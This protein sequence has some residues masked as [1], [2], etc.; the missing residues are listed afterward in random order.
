[1]KTLVGLLIALVVFCVPA[2][3]H[4]VSDGSTLTPEQRATLQQ[5]IIKASQNPVGNIAIVPFQNNFNYGVGP[6]ARSQNN[7]N[8]QPVVPIMLSDKWNLIARTILPIVNNPSALPPAVC[9]SVTGCPSTLAIGDLQE[10]FFF[11]PKTTGNGIIWGAGP[12]FQFPTGSPANFGSGQYSAGPAVVGLIMPGPWVM[13]VLVTQLWSLAG[14]TTGTTVSSFLLQPFINYNIK[15]GWAFSTSPI[16]TAN[17]TAPSF[18][19]WT[20][21]LGGGVSKTFKLGDQPMQVGLFYYGNVVRPPN[22]P[23]GQIRLNAALLFP[24]KRG[25]SIPK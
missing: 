6:F 10:Q 1:M 25:F 12:Q 20:I 9:A 16:M 19:K 2:A 14:S 22:A 7:L 24:V 8:I 17:W 13:G 21:P 4:T 11:A 18:Q 3:A 5:A 23:Y 15:G